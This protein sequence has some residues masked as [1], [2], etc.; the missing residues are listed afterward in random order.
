FVKGGLMFADFLT[1]VSP[2]YAKEIQ[3]ETGGMGLDGAVRKRRQDL[4]GILNGIDAGLWD[5][6]KDPILP[7]RFSAASLDGKA[8]CKARA[9]AALGLSVQ[10]DWML[11]TVVS[12]FTGQ[13]GLDLF[14]EAAPELYHRKI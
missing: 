9:Q 14:A 12:R 6:E 1:T 3:T 8:A 4:A 5:P 7:A 13:K 2:S 11:A 10:P